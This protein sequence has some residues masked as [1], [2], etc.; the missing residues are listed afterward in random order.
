MDRL[1]RIKTVDLGEDKEKRKVTTIMSTVIGV[2]TNRPQAERAAAEIRSEGISDD[3]ISV[4]A[5]EGYIHGDNNDTNDSFVNTTKGAR[6]SERTDN[7]EDDQNLSSGTTT[8]GALGG[9]TGLLAG[10]GLFTIP[11]LGPILALGPIVSGLAGATAGGIAGSLVDMG[12]SPE[13]SEHYEADVERGGILTAVECEQS[14]IND[15]ATVF[16]R[17]GAKDVETY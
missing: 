17:N 5:R 4:V 13:R 14:K 6:D 7:A 1:V 11:G 8:G 10:A 12:I 3:R 9:V 15:V 2:F 16:R